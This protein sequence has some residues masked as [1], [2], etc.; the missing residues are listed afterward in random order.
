MSSSK[1][2]WVQTGNVIAAL[3][4]LLFSERQLNCNYGSQAEFLLR[5]REVIVTLLALLFVRGQFN[6]KDGSQGRFE[7]YITCG[8]RWSD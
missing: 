7:G 6:C 5:W 2:K 1:D 3:L 8:S 4:A